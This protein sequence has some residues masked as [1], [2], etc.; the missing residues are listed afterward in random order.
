M[1]IKGN[2]LISQ[3]VEIFFYKYNVSY[4]QLTKKESFNIQQNWRNIFS[5]RLKQQKNTWKYK[6]FDWHT[7]SYGFAKHKSGIRAKELFKTQSSENYYVVP[8]DV[9]GLIYKCTSSE[10][11]DFSELC[12]DLY[13][14][15]D[16]IDWTMVFTHEEN[17]GIGPF[18]AL[19]DWQAI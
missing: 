13:I 7:F 9:D 14:F 15:P 16:T 12:L 10:F 3:E 5:I 6:Q 19:K 4:I 17:I 11:P 2:P 8:E 1:K 18:F